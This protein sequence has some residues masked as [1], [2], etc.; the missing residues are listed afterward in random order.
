[1]VIQKKRLKHKYI[2]RRLKIICSS[3]EVNIIYIIYSLSCLKEA[4][5]KCPSVPVA[6]SSTSHPTHTLNVSSPGAGPH[7][8][9]ASDFFITP[10]F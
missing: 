1:M 2:L 5:D 10:S 8:T 3:D 4:W 9:Q 6:L 7:L